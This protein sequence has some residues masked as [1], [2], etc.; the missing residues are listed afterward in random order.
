MAVYDALDAQRRSAPRPMQRWLDPMM[1]AERIAFVGATSGHFASYVTM[2][3]L[4]ET[5]PLAGALGALFFD[6]ATH[7]CTGG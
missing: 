3:R 6:F 2:Q 4:H 5:L 1:L 7:A